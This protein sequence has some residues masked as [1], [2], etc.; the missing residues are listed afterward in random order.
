MEDP[1]P[2]TLETAEGAAPA[3]PA[4]PTQ[5]DADTASGVGLE[6][7]DRGG[8]ECREDP[9][10]ETELNHCSSASSSTDMLWDTLGGSSGDESN[11]NFLSNLDNNLP[12]DSS[13]E[14]DPELTQDPRYLTSKHLMKDLLDTVGDS[15]RDWDEDER[16]KEEQNE[17]DKVTQQMMEM[18]IGYREAEGDRQGFEE[19]SKYCLEF[20]VW[21]LEK[22]GATM[23]KHEDRFIPMAAD[24]INN[25][26]EEKQQEK[27]EN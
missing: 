6:E 7:E 15:E 22:E 13:E 9:E 12:S 14:D 10:T 18:E 16:A 20:N 23:T 19:G 2:A 26:H 25:T 11:F 17:I 24:K 3:A 8:P 4:A 21:K 27:Q 5:P 1:A